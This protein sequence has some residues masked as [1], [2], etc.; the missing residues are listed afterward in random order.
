M[1]C[2]AESSKLSRTVYL[3]I[4]I[5]KLNRTTEANIVMDSLGIKPMAFVLRRNFELELLFQKREN[6]LYLCELLRGKACGRIWICMSTIET[7]TPLR[8]KR[9]MLLQMLTVLLLLLAILWNPIPIAIPVPCSP[10]QPWMQY[11]V[12]KLGYEYF[13][14]PLVLM[15]KFF[16]GEIFLSMELIRK[17]CLLRWHCYSRND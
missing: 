14:T 15:F 12:K 10:G 8:R 13:F 16:H 17:P 11:L 1:W 3:S 5:N 4:R 2:T 6:T 9:A 7:H